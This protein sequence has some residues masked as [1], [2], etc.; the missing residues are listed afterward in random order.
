MTSE[1]I[2]LGS[3]KIIVYTRSELASLAHSYTLSSPPIKAP[4]YEAISL[5]LAPNRPCM[6]LVLYYRTL[7]YN[8][9]HYPTYTIPSLSVYS[10]LPYTILHYLTIPYITLQYLH[11]PT[12][13]YMLEATLLVAH[14]PTVLG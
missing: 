2:S 12:L 5:R 10:T 6:S 8:T 3:Q 1:V 14:Y 9:L 4:G 11:Y 13:P 7:P